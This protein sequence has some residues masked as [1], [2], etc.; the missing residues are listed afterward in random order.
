MTESFQGDFKFDSQFE[1]G[2]LF[3]VFEKKDMETDIKQF[4]L[5]LQ[6]DINTKGFSNW[7]YFS[8]RC[9]KKSVIKLNIV[10]MQ[11][12]YSI[13]NDGMKVTIFSVKRYEN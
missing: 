6:N 9:K 8:I 5:I 12:N 7:F 11:K 1:S 13:F 2:N 10:N 3:A 4:D